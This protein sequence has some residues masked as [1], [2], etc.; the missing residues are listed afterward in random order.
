MN[1]Y[2]A[3]IADDEPM[4]I[5]ILTASLSRYGIE[6]LGAGKNGDELE[7]LV[8]SKNP[9]IIVTDKDMPNLD[10]G[11][12]TI[13]RLRASGITTPVILNTGRAY[14]L[15]GDN[16]EWEQKAYQGKREQPMPYWKSASLGNTVLVAKPYSSDDFTGLVKQLVDADNT[17]TQ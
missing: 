17:R 2:R 10:E 8:L 12:R 14:D 7:A 6:V 16:S 11:I 4:M 3:V 5:S 15:L 13:Q 1:E 9:N